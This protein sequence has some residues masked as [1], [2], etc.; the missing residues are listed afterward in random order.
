MSFQ[1]Y[2]DTV[3]E[4]TGKT[5]ADFRTESEAQGLA[6]HGE[7]VAWLKRDY[8]LGHG[9]ANAIAAALLKAEQFSAPKDDRADAVFAGKKTAW[10]PAYDA[11]W[12]AVQA[13]GDDVGLAPTDTYVS[14]TRGGKKFAI[15]Q[16]TA[17]RLDLGLKRRGVEA[18]ARFEA[19]GTW[20][21]MVTHRVR[22]TDAAQIDAEVMA[23]LRAAYEG[24]L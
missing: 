3:K 11:L 16:P 6:K 10:K 8:S 23:W 4:K 5:V 21:S 20:N 2:L 7:I 19:A 14:F 9:H 17:P 24:A 12:A 18:T 13:Y 15:V 22:I 1:A